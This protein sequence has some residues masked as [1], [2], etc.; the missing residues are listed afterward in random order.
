MA[1]N[2]VAMRIKKELD[3]ERK[4]LAEKQ[5]ELRVQLERVRRLQYDYD[6]A[7]RENAN[8]R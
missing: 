1:T 2:L 8:W 5:E 3:V 4:K 7:I 6:M